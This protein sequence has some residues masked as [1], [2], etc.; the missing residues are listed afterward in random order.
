MN[1]HKVPFDTIWFNAISC[2]NMQYHEI[3][4]EK[5]PTTDKRLIFIWEKGTLSFWQLCPVAAS[6]RVTVESKQRKY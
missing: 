3:P 4:Y 5:K 6:T 2:N 1:Y